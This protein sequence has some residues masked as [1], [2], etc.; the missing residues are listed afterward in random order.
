MPEG[1]VAVGHR[2]ELQRGHVAHQGHGGVE[3]AVG[4][5]VVAV[6]QRDQLLADMGAVAQMKIADTANLVG[7]FTILDMGI[8]HCGVPLV[9][10]C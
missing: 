1:A 6:R 5:D 7:R 8:G 9:V 10:D 2:L 3:D 4:G